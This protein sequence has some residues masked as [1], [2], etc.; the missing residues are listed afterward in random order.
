MVTWTGGGRR[1]TPMAD[2]VFTCALKVYTTAS[3][4]RFAG[5]LGDAYHGGYLSQ[6]INSVSVCAF[7]ENARLTPVFQHL[8]VQSSLPLSLFETSFA[9]DSSGFSTSRFVRWHDEKYGRERSRHD[10]VKAHAICGVK[11]NIVTAVEIGDR[12]AADCPFFKPLLETTAE[13]FR[14]REVP[15]DKAYLSQDNL[16]LVQQ[17]GGT[18][19]VPYKVNSQPGEAGSLWEKMYFYFQFRRDEFLKHYHQRS[20]MESTFA[21][22]KAK[23]RDHVRSRTETAMKNE[24]LCKFLC[25]NLCVVHQSHIELGITPVFWGER[26][27]T[28]GAE[29]AGPSAL[30]P[31]SGE[32]PGNG[33]QAGGLLSSR[34]LSD[35]S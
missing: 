9:P 19:Y 32:Q 14:V 30:G 8:I 3:S 12:D 6:R 35:N 13:H 27:T 34:K 23:F 28:A 24:V 5:D 16:A 4:R 11:T 21:M 17:L 20:N 18:A 33:D 25:H 7:L 29:T 22:V 10:W 26:P 1:W 15:A 2:M 31:D